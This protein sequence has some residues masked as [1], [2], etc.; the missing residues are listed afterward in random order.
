M[1]DKD[2][3]DLGRHGVLIA[4][5]VSAG[6]TTVLRHCLAGLTGG[7]WGTDSVL[8]LRFRGASGVQS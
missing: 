5:A 7:E 3:A 2:V 6:T 4:G 1:M 8:P